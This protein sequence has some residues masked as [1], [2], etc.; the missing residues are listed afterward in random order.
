MRALGVVASSTVSGWLL[1]EIVATGNSSGQ[2]NVFTETKIKIK[3][4]AIQIWDFAL[5][6]LFVL[7]HIGIMLA[8]NCEYLYQYQ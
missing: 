6:G 4:R 7:W 8:Y 3:D 2:A 1:L 5:T